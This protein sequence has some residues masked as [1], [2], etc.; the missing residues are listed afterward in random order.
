M[1]YMDIISP[2]ISPDEL[3]K[4]NTTGCNTE[5]TFKKLLS[6]YDLRYV[7][8]NFKLSD[9]IIKKISN[10]KYSDLEEEKDLTYDHIMFCQK[11]FYN[12]STD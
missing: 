9:D 5:E 12:K 1:E 11:L 2:K 3:K 4:I 7:I 10:N 8:R 6:V